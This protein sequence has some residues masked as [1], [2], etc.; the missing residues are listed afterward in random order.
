MPSLT[1]ADAERRAQ[2]LAVTAYAIDLDLTGGDDPEHPT[3]GSRST[4]TFTAQPGASSFLDIKAVDVA[5]ITLN[6]AAVDP[7]TVADGRVELTGLAADNTVVVEATMGYSNDGQGLHRAID[8]A[9]GLAYVYGH[10]FLDAAPRVFACFDQPDL[11]APYT[12]TITA[13]QA[14]TVLGNGA[15][16]ATGPGRWELATTQPLATYFVTICAG[17][18]ASVTDEHDGIPLGVHARASLA[19]SLRAQAPA[20]LQVTKDAFDYYHQLFGIRYPFGSYHQ[21]FVPEFNAGAMENPG[22]VTFRDTYLFRGAATDDEL[23]TRANTICHEMAHMWFGDLVTMQW[24]DDLWLNESFAE[25]MAHR[26][27]TAISGSDDAWVDSTMSRKAWGYAAERAPSTHPVAGS[28]APDADA[29]LQ[30]FDGISYAKGAAVLRQLICHLGDEAFVAGITAYLTEHAYGNAALAD[31]LGAMEAA[32]G[33]DLT[34][35]SKVWLTTAGVDTLAAAMG[36]DGLRVTRRAPE[37]VPAQRPHTLDVAGW[38]GGTQVLAADVV[39]DQDEVLVRADVA[40]SV[41]LLIPN[42]GDLTWAQVELDAAS[43]TALP[44][45]LPRVSQAQHRAVV[46]VALTDGLATARVDPRL[47]VDIFVAA[48]PLE[49]NSSILSRS[50]ALLTSRVLADYLADAE[51]PS[52]RDAVAG[53][54]RARLES[55][56]AGSSQALAAAR[57]L[58]AATRDVEQLQ[59]WSGSVDLPAGLDGDPDFRWLVLR[60]LAGAGAVSA[61]DLEAAREAD[62]SMQG[63]L[64]AL[65]ALAA[66]PTAADKAWAWDQLVGDHGRSNHE[67]N[68]LASGFWTGRHTDLVRE[69][70]AAFHRDIPALEGRVGQDALARVAALAYPRSVVDEATITATDDRLAVGDLSP[71]VHRSL[72]DQ[73]SVLREVLASRRAFG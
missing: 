66:L 31:F 37:A 54:A 6:G 62:H 56:P 16:T 60:S 71:A 13:P 21:V 57:I 67:R 69:Y 10:L 46:W 26:T 73:Q 50:G 43:L 39:L 32:S 72:V 30:N 58:A 44:V 7:G 65:A 9:D 41:G 17:P 51:V 34:E 29:A 2:T 53:A 1:R 42:A 55:A 18:Y 3:F 47:V 68:A 27:L 5:S 61:A 45:E 20:M 14:W 28:P 48:W 63:N 8:P 25:Y 19:E 11:K 35:W 24:W 70:V 64:G 49:E 40:G 52:A 15:A 23:L 59:R 22:C 12:L 4:A 36:G 33:T 38:S